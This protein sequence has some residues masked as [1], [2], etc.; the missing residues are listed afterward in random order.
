MGRRSLAKERRAQIIAVT[1]NCMAVHG[2][3]GTT[4]E[5][6]AE[7][8]S[9][10]RGHVR[11][12]VGNRDNLLT[13]AARVFYFGDEAMDVSDLSAVV[14]SSPFLAPEA[15]LADALDYLFGSFG[16]PGADNR[17]VTAFVDASHTIPAIGEIIVH[18]YLSIQQSLDGVL[19]RAYPTAN[20]RRRHLVA[21]SLLTQA[22]G[23][24]FL[25]DVDERLER[26]IDGRS[27]AEEMLAIL[28]TPAGG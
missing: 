19:E 24:T 1:I 15:T 10:T 27:A 20:A 3:A 7:M 22:I 8:A 6:I 23:T 26:L 9:M 4:L 16:E 2:F 28:G 13:D 17:S 12:Y 25:T 21:Y 18:A 5:R 14:A 11:H